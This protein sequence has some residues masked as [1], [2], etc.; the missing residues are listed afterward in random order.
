MPELDFEEA[1]RDLR[2]RIEVPQF[3]AVRSRASGIRRRRRSWSAA[4]AALACVLALGTGTAVIRARGDGPGNVLTSADAMPAGAVWRSGPITLRGL[5]GSV[6]DLPGNLR[7]VQ[8]ADAEHAYALS[9]RCER[10]LG[11]P[12]DLGLAAS[13]DGGHTW[14]I[15]APPIA[16]APADRLPRLITLDATGIVLSGESTW[17]GR[18]GQPGWQRID[19]STP[20]PADAPTDA[21]TRTARLRLDP[22]ATGGCTGR[23][24]QVWRHDGSV[25]QLPAQPDMDVCWVS[26]APAADGAWWVGGTKGGTPAVGRS[27][28]YG[29]TW[30]VFPLAGPAGA[31]AQVSLLGGDVYAI[32]VSARGG[33]PYPETLSIQSAFR[34]AAGSPFAA[35]GDSGGADH[36]I[37]TLIGDVVPLLDGRLVAAGPNW[38]LTDK[39]GAALIPAS[40][41]LPWVYRLQATP[42]GWVALDLFHNGWAAVSRDGE[43]WQK[44]NVR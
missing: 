27:R 2:G 33:N 28:D 10:G 3:D 42:G 37:G 16:E 20:H 40:N 6:L 9:A 35:Y 5:N 22:A 25:G 26:S 41:S 13:A 21:P 31:W 24:V 34:S 18:Y 17:F 19:T 23:P 43:N 4:G 36:T 11:Q 1:R 29:R 14:E 7:D 15:W 39:S 8:F 32:V 30:Q 44:I 12:C 38:Y